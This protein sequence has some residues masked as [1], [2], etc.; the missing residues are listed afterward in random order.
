MNRYQLMSGLLN[1]LMS[2]AAFTGNRHTKSLQASLI[3]MLHEFLEFRHTQQCLTFIIRV[4]W[5]YQW[6]KNQRYHQQWTELP[7]AKTWLPRRRCSRHGL[8][9]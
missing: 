3:L 2:P 8:D 6:V 4:A 9:R 1:E 5:A 7:F